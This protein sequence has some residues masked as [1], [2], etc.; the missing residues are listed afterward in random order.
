MKNI[1]YLYMDIRELKNK[2]E[3]NMLD[4]SVLILKYTDNKFLCNHYINSIIEKR[5]KI[6]LYIHSINEISNDDSF[7]ESVDNYLYV[8]DVD[9]LTEQ[10]DDS[11]KNLI[12]ITKEVPEDL[13]IDY[14]DVPKLLNW[15]IEDYVKMRLEGLGEKEI[16]WLCDITKHNIYRLENEC[17]KLSLFPPLAR[18]NIFKEFNEEDTYSD[19]SSLN[20]FNF[21]TALLK[22]DYN[23]INEILKSK[24]VIDIEGIGLV[25][26]LYKNIK[27][28]IDIQFNSNAT[29][30]KLGMPPKQFAAVKYSVGKYTNSQLIKM[31]KFLTSLDL[32]LKSGG[33]QFNNNSRDN[34]GILVDYVTVN[35]LRL[36]SK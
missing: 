4:D 18:K 29:A 16:L 35:I 24:S 14:I 28:I 1:V 6:K 20:I 27:N 8:L 21:S 9:K 3:N 5:N 23:T 34:N 30:E 7:F 10:V 2:I 31:F 36:G 13:G 12:I 17:N 22:K 26:I 11:Y 25:T 19:L 15:Q 32:K 33:L